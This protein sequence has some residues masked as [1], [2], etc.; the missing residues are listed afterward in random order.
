MN[1]DTT[2]IAV[3]L[4]TFIVGVSIVNVFSNWFSRF[5]ISI[6]IVSLVVISLTRGSSGW[7]ENLTA[8]LGSYFAQEPFGLVGFVLGVLVGAFYR[9]RR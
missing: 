4:L 9:G 1:L 7:I 5:L 2:H 8:N 3:L 6:G